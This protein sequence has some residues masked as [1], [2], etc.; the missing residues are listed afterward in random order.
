M[1]RIFLIFIIILLNP[2]FVY[3]NE[4]ID[5][6]FKSCI[7]GDTARFIVNNQEI[8]V[9][10]LAIDTPETNHPQKKEELYGKEAKEYTCNK[11][12]NANKIIL[13]FDNNSE[14]KDKYNRYLAWVFVDD[15]LIQKE[16]IK[17][18]LA[19]VAYIYGDYKYTDE[20][21]IEEQKA[22]NN[23]IGLFSEIDKQKTNNV[24]TEYTKKYEN[25]TRN[26][27]MEK[28]KVNEIIKIIKLIIK[29]II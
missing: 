11:I 26:T 13:E 17:N 6:K 18:G 4:K 5:A 21:L 9:R 28:K 14:K 25:K 27:K 10:F 29:K 3:A 8:K 22:K 24:V 12:T 16:L 2:N 20:L 19:K 15:N 1:K 7:D 23:K